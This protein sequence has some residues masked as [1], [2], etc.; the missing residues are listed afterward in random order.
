MSVT[1]KVLLA[2]VVVGVLAVAAALTLVWARPLATFGWLGE[3]SL[4][5]AGFAR[6]TVTTPAGRLTVFRG[7]AGPVVVLLHGAGDRAATWA[8]VAPALAR[9]YTVVIPDL[10]GHGGSGPA[11][12][13]LELGTVLAG[14]D[15]LLAGL[16]AG[17]VTL[18]G[19]S[20][21]A[22]IAM[23]EAADHP[24]RVTRL[25]LVNGGAL[26][27]EATGVNLLPAD[28]EEARRTVA[29]LRDPASPPVP[30]FVLDDI[31]R[32]ARS[33]PLARLAAGAGS[34]GQYLM[35]GRTGAIHAPVDILWG[36]SDRLMPLTYARRLAASMPSAR[37]TTIPRC[38]HVPHLECPAAFLA[39]LDEALARP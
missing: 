36:E 5:R 19:N 11:S 18:V 33:G 1:L 24:E 27:G 26:L 32:A 17:P 10:P 8:R 9:R 14:V 38:G 35:D 2:V 12:G 15:A 22:W 7:G 25:V 30:G 29:A 23:L 16:P 37:L 31:V 21:G 28:R 39:A 20:L 34:M 4:R 3:Q 6:S 13:P